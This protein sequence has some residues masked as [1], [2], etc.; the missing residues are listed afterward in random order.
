ML[1]EFN[2]Q[3]QRDTDNKQ[4]LIWVC[5]RM[6]GKLNNAGSELKKFTHSSWQNL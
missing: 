4:L 2:M 6:F 3:W 1:E 5:D